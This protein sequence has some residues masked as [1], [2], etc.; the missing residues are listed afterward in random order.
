MWGRRVGGKRW[1]K[2]KIIKKIK[3]G[4]RKKKLKDE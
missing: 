3:E 1:K 4:I 2:D